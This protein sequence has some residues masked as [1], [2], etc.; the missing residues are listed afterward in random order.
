MPLTNS[1]GG[2]FQP[3]SASH[4]NNFPINSSESVSFATTS[5]TTW[6]ASAVSSSVTTFV[7][8]S[9]AAP[10]ITEINLLSSP[11]TSHAASPQPRSS[12]LRP[13]TQSNILESPTVTREPPKSIVASPAR[14]QSVARTNDAYV[15]NSDSED[16]AHDTS[17][18]QIPYN[19]RTPS[20]VRS[21][22]NQINSTDLGMSTEAPSVYVHIPPSSPSA[23]MPTSANKKAAK[24]QADKSRPRGSG[25]SDSAYNASASPILDDAAYAAALAAQEETL[26]RRRPTRSATKEVSYSPVCDL[27]G[28]PLPSKNNSTKKDANAPSESKSMAITKHLAAEKKGKGK[29]TKRR[30]REFSDAGDGEEDRG[31]TPGPSS[32]TNARPT[33][34]QTTEDDAELTDEDIGF[35]S[36]DRKRARV[37]NAVSVDSD[38]EAPPNKSKVVVKLKPRKRAAEGDDD[39]AK[40]SS[41]ADEAE[42]GI[43]TP[44]A[45]TSPRR[46]SRKSVPSPKKQQLQEAKMGKDRGRQT[47]TFDLSHEEEAEEHDEEQPRTS[48]R[49]DMDASRKRGK[50]ASLE[51]AP[52]AEVDEKQAEA[53]EASPVPSASASAVSFS[54]SAHVASNGSHTIT[55]SHTS[56]K[57]DKSDS[58]P[59]PTS[60]AIKRTS[61][62]SHSGVIQTSSTL[63]SPASGPRSFFGKPLTT[64]LT[65]NAA[66]RPGLTRKTN[67]PSLLNHRGIPKPPAP[68]LAVSKRRMQDDDYEY[69]AAYEALIGNVKNGSDDEKKEDE[70]KSDDGGD[71]ALVIDDEVDV[72]LEY[73]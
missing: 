1:D 72:E 53:K 8:S 33:Q 20:P 44:P 65:R 16:C 18:A 35:K 51:P 47:K 26:A 17:A 64:L 36:N 56:D 2:L 70:E 58:R 22:T 10:T 15:V 29:G 4:P 9:A 5:A 60:V 48:N 32:T 66:R 23:N 61:N 25:A 12:P 50:S 45:P 7:D 62:C 11:P 43:L 28:K 13:S 69:D 30:A 52:E 68:K 55:D 6:P 46:S 38:D 59:S 71:K 37:S 3:M 21:N 40:A 67:I 42:D 63:S 54:K 27:H 24:S 31:N 73:D 41:G 34:T 57:Q 14:A 49:R 39:D 19:R